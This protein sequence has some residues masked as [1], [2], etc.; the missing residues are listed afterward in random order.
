MREALYPW[1]VTL[2]REENSN[3]KLTVPQISVTI[4]N[5]TIPNNDVKED[6]TSCKSFSPGS[7]GIHG[8]VPGGR[9][10]AATNETP[11][12]AENEGY[13]MVLGEGEWKDLFGNSMEIT[14]FNGFSCES[15][16]K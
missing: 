4:S 5:K 13:V 7:L 15:S 12:N 1:L 16:N 14:S 8:E 11:L 10:R 3:I 2:L 9:N 6:E